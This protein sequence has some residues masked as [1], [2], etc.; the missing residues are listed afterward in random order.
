MFNRE[1]IVNCGIM[2]NFGEKFG[3]CA[4]H[5]SKSGR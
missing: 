5:S 2:R 4:T 1:T 3:A